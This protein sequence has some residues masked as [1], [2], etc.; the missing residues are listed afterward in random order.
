MLLSLIK[1]SFFGCC[2]IWTRGEL[3]NQG[4]K[5][6]L[7]RSHIFVVV[8]VWLRLQASRAE[9]VGDEAAI[10]ALLGRVAV[11]GDRL[12]AFSS[13]S[14]CGRWWCCWCWGWYGWPL[15]SRTIPSADT[16]I[17]KQQ[18]E[19]CRIFTSFGFFRAHKL[20]TL[21]V[22]QINL[23]V[24]WVERNFQYFI[25]TLHWFWIGLHQMKL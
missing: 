20:E 24:Y 23:C 6:S 2:E 19:F 17:A 10:S 1:T 15:L 13:N 18:L 25:S 9:A 11:S 8:V 5:I 12:A 21:L 14:S 7:A 16:K 4:A 3:L 22:N